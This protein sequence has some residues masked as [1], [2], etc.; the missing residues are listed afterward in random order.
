M[1]PDAIVIV[2]VLAHV[3]DP[4]RLP[5]HRN[6][7]DK[8]SL[9]GASWIGVKVL[10][11]LGSNP[12]LGANRIDVAVAQEDRRGRRA[13]ER[14][15]GIGQGPENQVQIER[16][17]ADHLQNVG[18]RSLLFQGLGQVT[19][20]RLHFIKQAHVVDGDHSLFGK[21][22]KERDLPI[23]ESARLE[24]HEGDHADR[25]AVAKHR[26]SQNGPEAKVNDPSR[27]IFQV[28]RDVRDVDDRAKSGSHVTKRSRARVRRGKSAPSRRAPPATS[29][30]GRQDG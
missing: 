8:G 29:C 27:G 28:F 17:T 9:A 23:G 22:L 4:H 18:G 30:S 2:G 6:A 11:K 7:S 10:E 12:R 25:L 15:R 3:G 24:A 16:R 13:A 1:R 5:G 21:R 14:P 20:A 19:G 26:H